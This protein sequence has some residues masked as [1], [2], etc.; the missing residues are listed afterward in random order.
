MK[1][2]IEISGRGGEVVLGRVKR[3]I[4]DYFEE[5]EVDIEEYAS[6]WDNEQNVP[7]EF[8]PFEPGSWYDC[9]DLAHNCGPSVDYCYITVMDDN[10]VVLYD[11]LTLDAFMD[12]GAEQTQDEEVYPSNELS[13]GEAYFYGQSHEKGHF[14]AVEFEAEAF[15]PAKLVFATGDYDGW[16]LVTGISYDGNSL[17]DQGDLSTTG[18]SS[19]FGLVLVEKD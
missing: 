10:Q 5:N 1:Y 7:E 2:R 14:I 16:E 18:K 11:S 4:Y 6:N 12:L 15:D 13:D 3:E 17:D 8:Q 19:E 9:D